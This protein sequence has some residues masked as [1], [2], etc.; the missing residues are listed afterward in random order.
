MNAR[1]ILFL[2]ARLGV[3]AVLIFVIGRQ[4]QWEDR[5][6]VLE[7]AERTT[8]TGRVD[9][10]ARSARSITIVTREGDRLE[11]SR[12]RIEGR[13]P[14]Y[15]LRTMFQQMN[16][17]YFGFAFLCMAGTISITA[18]RWR[19]L[20]RI[21]GIPLRKSEAIRLT[22]LGLFF[23]NA[24]PGATGGDVMKAYYAAR[25]REDK[26]EVFAS[27]FLDRIIGLVALIVLAA[28]VLL[29]HSADPK[30]RR[31]AVNVSLFLVV[32]AIGGT[33]YYSRRLRRLSGLSSLA[34]RLPFQSQFRKVDRGFFHYRFHK[35]ALAAAFGVS[36]LA[37]GFTIVS[38]VFIGEALRFDV[39]VESYF[40]FVPIG[41]VASA[42]PLF[43]GGW[44]VREA[45]YGMLFKGSGLPFGYG[46]A[47]GILHG[48][49]VVAWSLVGGVLFL[50][51]HERLPKRG[52]DD[53]L[54]DGVAGRV[55]PEDPGTDAG[56]SETSGAG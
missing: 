49:I 52:L 23:N 2:V 6:T 8:Y 51:G 9:K 17:K 29:F 53:A 35:G 50:S 20:V 13:R 12:D 22:Y 47:L 21:R 15:G 42:I 33:V 14:L 31:L 38:H 37:H 55:D 7:G 11:I 48:L 45:T 3:F 39:D 40:V 30:F 25:D 28:V 1:R 10:E 32:L 4:L 36:F 27:V 24:V 46:A 41:Q 19:Q 34:T 54:V 43:P 5:V 16:W 26:A 56:R 18:L 44:G